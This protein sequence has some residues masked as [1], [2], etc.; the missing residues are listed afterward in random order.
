MAQTN[1]WIV[2]VPN[3][4]KAPEDH[5][6][7]AKGTAAK[8]RQAKTRTKLVTALG[9]A[10]SPL[11]KTFA[12]DIPPLKVGTLD[13]LMALSDELQKHDTAIFQLISRIERSYAEIYGREVEDDK[14]EGKGEAKSMGGERARVPPLTVG[15]KGDVPEEYVRNFEWNFQ[16]Y[17]YR[18]ATLRAMV[19]QIVKDTTKADSELKR[20]FTEYN[21]VRNA[22]LT[23]E[24]KEQGTLMVRPIAPY[25][26]ERD[27]ID[28]E[29]L[30]TVFIVIPKVKQEEFMSEYMGYER[31]WY[32]KDEVDQKKRDDDARADRERQV[33]RAGPTDGLASPSDSKRGP[34]HDDHDELSIEEQKRKAE[35]DRAVQAELE[36]A[37]AEKKREAAELASRK[38]K[39]RKTPNIVPGSAK[40]LT[41]D[42][43]FALVKLNVLRKGLDTF[44]LI[45]REKRFTVRDFKWDPAQEITNKQQ[46]AKLEKHKKEMHAFLTRWCKGTFSEVFSAWV[47][48]KAMRVFVEAVLR[49]GLPV[50]FSASLLLPSKNQ[51]K[52]VRQ[53]LKDLYGN[54]AAANLT[55]ALDASE[56]DLSGMGQD[57]YPYVFLTLTLGAE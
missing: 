12:F 18:R 47:H 35:A 34:A 42:A 44:K 4:T 20:Q 56:A 19:E 24:R 50:N 28:R 17:P 23:I 41:T 37:A 51:D 21:D 32:A 22:C 55:Q 30:A 52:K 25:I 39:E 33:K 15:E 29:F 10:S 16:R 40:V 2:A 5:Q 57:F 11:C 45:C 7:D 54:L 13:S 26:K 6:D 1:Y 27:F 3:S 9:G 53:V 49:Y 38:A 8:A 14:E 36:A 48:V 31:A 43:E 46:L